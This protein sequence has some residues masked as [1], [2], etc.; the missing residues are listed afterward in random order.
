MTD[1]KVPLI[2]NSLA[3]KTVPFD[4]GPSKIRAGFSV[5]DADY[6]PISF[7]LQFWAK[8]FGTCG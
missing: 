6:K 1:P 3:D 2:F 7:A 4:G 8:A 5:G